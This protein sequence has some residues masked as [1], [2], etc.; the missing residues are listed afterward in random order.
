MKKNETDY[1]LE[2]MG[3][4]QVGLQKAEIDLQHHYLVGVS[5]GVD[6]V[7]LAYLLKACDISFSIAHLN[8]GARDS[9]SQD[10]EFVRRFADALHV[11]LFT[12]TIDVPSRQ[13]EEKLSFE[14]A[15]RI[16]RYRFLIETAQNNACAGV[17]VGHQA[18]DQVETV[19]MHLLRGSGIAG[20]AGMAYREVNAEFSSE[21]PILRPMLAVWRESILEYANAEKLSYVTDESNHDITFFRNRLRHHLI[22]VL[23]EY[24]QQARLHVWQSS[25]IAQQ[26]QSLL[27]HTLD[28]GWQKILLHLSKDLVICD[29]NKFLDNHIELQYLVI[30]RILGHLLPS[31]RDFDYGLTLSTQAMI[32]TPPESNKFQI[33]EPIHVLIHG[34][35]FLVGTIRAIGEK[36]RQT[37]PQWI[38]GV[39]ALSPGDFTVQLSN[40]MVLKATIHQID[41]IEEKEWRTTSLREA[42]IDL[43]T[44]KLPLIL[45]SIEAGD[46]FEP[47]GMHGRHRKLSDFMIDL[48]VPKIVR[49]KYP[50]LC[51]QDRIVWV[52]G[53]RIADSNKITANTHSVIHLELT[54]E[55]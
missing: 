46:R 19:L 55:N 27:E 54:S 21:I 50:V 2:L 32:Q 16:Y 40:Q 18:D 53:Q 23:E 11:E 20:L 24:N 5:G 37:Y 41:E 13:M 38:G 10:Q 4:F 39:M 6:S 31:M 45:R 7:I 36:L 52:V 47:F 28:D 48:K 34:D 26:T 22:P 25:M 3:E 15:A 17:I 8:H 35:T 51:D 1:R 33:I 43:D 14:E 9:A 49:D 44:L 12:T 42:W 29:R 30:R